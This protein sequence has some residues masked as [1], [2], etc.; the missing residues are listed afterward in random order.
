[1]GMLTTRLISGPMTSRSREE[2]GGP[3]M[4]TPSVSDQGTAVSVL[5]NPSAA[6]NAAEDEGAARLG[7]CAQIH[8]PT[9]GTCEMHRGHEGS[10]TF[11]PAG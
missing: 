5:P 10:C 7:R 8:L 2:L 11:S 3:F 9:G 1:M 6:H 4:D